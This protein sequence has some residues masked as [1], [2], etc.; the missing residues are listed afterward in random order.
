MGRE[1]M[2]IPFVNLSR[3]PLDIRA[4]WVESMSETISQGRF[5]G[6]DVV[7]KFEKH[8]ASY[9]GAEHA[10]G[11]GNGLDAI[12][13]SLKALGIK[14]G[15]LV[16][17]PAHTFIATWFAVSSIGAVPYGVDVDSEGGINLNELENLEAPIA[18][19]VPVHM[20]GLPVDMPRLMKWAHRRGV[21]VVED[22]SQAHGAEVGGRKVGSW[23]NA[24]AFSLYPTKNLGAIGDAG[25]VTTNDNT[26]AKEVREIANYGS[27]GQDKYR[28]IRQGVN[29]RLDP[30]QAG[31][32]SI[33]LR[34]L[35]GWNERRRKI[36]SFYLENL[37]GSSDLVKP[38]HPLAENSVWHHFVIISQHRDHL[39]RYL[40][41]K[42]IATELHYPNSAA[43]EYATI[44]GDIA[45]IEVKNK[46]PVAV[47]ISDFGLSIPLHPWLF[48]SEV[49]YIALTLSSFRK[50]S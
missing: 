5:I 23:G 19:V 7:S 4:L 32:L 37:K 15:Q 17:V 35:D 39:R 42:G 48:D 30:I 43:I 24:G 25:I 45:L 41:E 34:F 38:L 12:S 47:S 21:L 44:L 6:G 16:A 18:A 46:Y 20:H 22:C 28:H 33:N 11:V 36:S 26:L 14:P 3:V 10:I 49:E 1:Q 29:S 9:I 8:W 13:I 40:T 27:A 50:I 2:N 31:V